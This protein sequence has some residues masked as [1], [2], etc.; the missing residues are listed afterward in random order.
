MYKKFED[1]TEEQKELVYKM[2]TDAPVIPDF[3]YGWDDKGLFLGRQSQAEF[4]S[5]SKK[6]V[7]TDKAEVKAEKE[8]E[9]AEKKSK[10]A[11]HKAHKK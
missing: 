3:Y 10:A 2:Y 1:L 8:D 6:K 7:E 4:D 5:A 9:A 11:E